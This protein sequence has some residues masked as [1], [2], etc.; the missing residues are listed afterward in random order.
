MQILNVLAPVF[1]MI[2]VGAWLQRSRFASPDFFKEANRLTYWLGLP[3]LLFSQLAGSYHEMGGA[4]LMLESTLL[5]TA[6]LG[7]IA[8][9]TAWALRI[10]GPSTGTFVQASFRGNLAFIG[11]PVIYSLPDVPLAHGGSM[12][13]ATVVI[14]APM[15]V[16]YNVAGVVVLM[17]SQHTLG[18]GMVKPV[19]KGLATNP[20]LI[21]TVVG[22]I[23]VAEGWTLP[24]AVD[25]TFSALG[26][27][28][29][30]LG[31]LGVGASLVTVKLSGNWKR[32]LGS[33]ALKI[34]VA[35]ALVWL[36]GV[37]MGLSGPELK[38][39]MILMAAPTAIVSYTIAMEMKGDEALA[40]GAIVLSVLASLPALAVIVGAF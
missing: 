33:T 5:A 25:K 11:L 23:F 10:P 1:L 26:E 9:A 29:L 28:A 8:Y 24:L 20:P 4:R 12:R 30:P 2:A 15:M 6:A 35:P 19:A 34:F 17:L 40:S 38:I 16:I 27:M 18:W 32:S 39:V 14:I 37:R 21:A 13:T 7:L 22:L 36:I 3:A 31:L